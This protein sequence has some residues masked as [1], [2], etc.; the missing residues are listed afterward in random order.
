MPFV[1]VAI[2]PNVFLVVATVEAQVEFNLAAGNGAVIRIDFEFEDSAADFHTQ[3]FLTGEDGLVLESRHRNDVDVS[4]NAIVV[5]VVMAQD[6]NGRLFAAFQRLYNFL[7]DVA[8]RVGRTSAGVHQLE[9]RRRPADFE[10][11]VRLDV[12]DIMKVCSPQFLSDVLN[13]SA[14][15]EPRSEPAFVVVAGDEICVD[16]F[17]VGVVV[18]KILRLAVNGGRQNRLAVDSS[19]V[20]VNGI[21][22]VKDSVNPLGFEQVVLLVECFETFLFAAQMGVSYQTDSYPVGRIETRKRQP[23]EDRLFEALG[24]LGVRQAI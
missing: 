1:Q 6:Q 7:W 24:F 17:S 12:S 19:N 4:F 18:R 22:R 11:D 20:S 5:N 14:D 3:A 15:V 10:F 9:H 21:A 23:S 13:V 8:A 16:A 2:R